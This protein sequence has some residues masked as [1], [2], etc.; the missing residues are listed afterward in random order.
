MIFDELFVLQMK[1]LNIFLNKMN[2]KNNSQKN[3]KHVS[4]IEPKKQ[5][6]KDSDGSQEDDD[7]HVSNIV[8]F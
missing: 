6:I 3:K 4:S 2:K 7:D 1:N 8:A 5:H